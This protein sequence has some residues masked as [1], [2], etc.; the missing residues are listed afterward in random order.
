MTEYMPY[1]VSVVCSLISGIVSYL[2][3]R[4]QA[5]TDLQII[6]KQHEVDIEALEKKHQMELE[7]IDIEHKHQL[8][9]QQKEMEA[10]L[11]S[12]LLTEAMKIP[13]VRNE[14]SKGMR[15]GKR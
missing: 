4:K 14:I 13:E 6:S 12:S 3:T 1:I 10:N 8:E 9:L 2:V 11:G 7:K 15:K 5:K